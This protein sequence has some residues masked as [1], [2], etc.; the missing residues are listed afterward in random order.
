[1]ATV[2]GDAGR[3]LAAWRYLGADT[4]RSIAGHSKHSVACRSRVNLA[5]SGVSKNTRRSSR[6]PRGGLMA[7]GTLEHAQRSGDD[8]V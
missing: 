6:P 5:D 4:P 3:V 2:D 8:A 1:M 7:E